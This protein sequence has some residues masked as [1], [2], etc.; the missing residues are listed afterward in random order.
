MTFFICVFGGVHN[1]TLVAD[2]DFLPN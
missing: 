1:L 2:N